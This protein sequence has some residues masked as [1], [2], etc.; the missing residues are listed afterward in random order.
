[1]VL[2][3]GIYVTYDSALL[4]SGTPFAVFPIDKPGLTNPIHVAYSLDPALLSSADFLLKGVTYTDRGTVEFDVG[5]VPSGETRT[6]EATASDGA[7]AIAPS[8]VPEPTTILLLTMA[9]AGLGVTRTR[10]QRKH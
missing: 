7:I 4:D 3:D 6:L 10:Q 9:L 1:M 2:S 5:L 8:T